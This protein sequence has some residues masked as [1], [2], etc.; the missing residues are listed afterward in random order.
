MEK[1]TSELLGPYAEPR[2]W[3]LRYLAVS[4]FKNELL[5]ESLQG[6][7]SAFSREKAAYLLGVIWGRLRQMDQ[8]LETAVEYA[9][10][11][12]AELVNGRTSA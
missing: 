7:W 11:V 1:M 6:N 3:L 5:E 8:S 12:E 2:Q 4:R 9:A 10:L